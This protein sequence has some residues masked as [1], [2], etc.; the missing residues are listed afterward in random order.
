VHV[1]SSADESNVYVD[2][3]LRHGDVLHRF[4]SLGKIPT[5]IR[6]VASP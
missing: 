1:D 2:V 4:E 6:R 5:R 3:S